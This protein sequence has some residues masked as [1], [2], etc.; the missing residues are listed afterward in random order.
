MMRMAQE[1]GRRNDV[2]WEHHVILGRLPR[3]LTLPFQKQKCVGGKMD[4]VTSAQQWGCKVIPL[5]GVVFSF[6]MACVFK[7]LSY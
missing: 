4:I 6:H 1:V 5:E 3:L 7:M 2:M